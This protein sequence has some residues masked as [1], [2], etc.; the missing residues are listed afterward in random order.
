MSS[1]QGTS[2]SSSTSNEDPIREELFSVERLEQYAAELAAEHSVSPKPSRGRRLLPRLEENGRR[3]ISVYR[4]LA[5]AIQSERA[6]SPAA[7]WLVDNFHIIEEQLREIRRDLPKGYYRE[8]PKLDKG[9]LAGYPRVYAIALALIAHTDSRLDADTLGRFIR[10]YQRVT[11]L[12]I[13]ELWA[14]AI[15]LRVALVEN[16]RRL[17][18]R[19]VEARNARE[20]ADRLADNLLEIAGRQPDELIEELQAAMGKARRLD[21]AFIVQLTQ[22]LRD[23]DPEVWPALECTGTTASESLSTE[24]IVH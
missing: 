19:I 23:Q 8:L 24:Q 22:R 10:S 17:A 13:G 2:R 11:P 5:D 16:L 7:E 6:V 20:E 1:F 14:I 9:D 3:L 12:S 21:R 4:A 15:T 18:T